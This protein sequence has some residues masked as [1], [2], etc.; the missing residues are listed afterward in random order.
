[1]PPILWCWPTTSEMDVG[2]TAIEAEP[3]WQNGVWHG[4]V[5]EAKM[6]HWI[7]PRRTKLHLLTFISTHWALTETKEW[8]WSQQGNVWCTSASMH[9]KQWW[10][11]WNITKFAPGGSRECS[12]RNRKNIICKFVRTIKKIQSLSGQF[13]GLYHHWW[14]DTMSSLRAWV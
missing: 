7:P 11:C 13:P 14:W 12:H 9:W 10:Q 1:M 4:S 6:C 2:V 8:M 5:A 3:P